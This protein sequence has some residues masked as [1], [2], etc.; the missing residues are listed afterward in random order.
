MEKSMSDTNASPSL[1]TGHPMTEDTW[2]DFV[3]RLRHNCNGQGVKWHH[4]ACALFTVQQKCIDYG[5]EADYAEGLT[6]CLEDNSWFSPEDYWADL[7]KDEQEELN[8]MVQAR[9]ECDF[10]ELVADDQ[11]EVLDELDDHIVTGWNKHWKS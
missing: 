5:Y 3:T 10:L 4:T 6:V 2:Q 7:D 11:W 8:R 1:A 9:N